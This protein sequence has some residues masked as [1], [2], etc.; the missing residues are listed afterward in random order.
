MYRAAVSYKVQSSPHF[1]K[2]SAGRAVSK[3]LP[4]PYHS[5]MNTLLISGCR[6]HDAPPQSSLVDVLVRGSTLDVIGAPPGTPA[7]TRLD[8]GGRTL[9]PGLIDLHL[10]GAGGADVLDGTPE[11]LET[12]SRALAR[13]GTTAFLATSVPQPQRGDRHLAAAAEQVGRKLGGARLLGQYLEGPFVNPEKRGGI[14][15]SSL[16]SPSRRVLDEILALTDGTLRIMTLAPELEGN[17]ALVERLAAEGIIAAFGHSAATYEQTRAGIAAGITHCTHLFNAMAGLHHREPGPLPA[18][19]ESEHVTVELISDGVHVSG[20]VVRFTHRAFGTERCVCI[21]DAM[22]TAGMPD[23]R[24]QY[25]GREF[26]SKEG[27][28]RYLD[29]TLIGTALSLREVALRFREYTGCTFAEAVDAATLVPARVLGIEE[30]KGSIAVG[31]DADLVLL[32]AD[33]SVWATLVEGEV[34]YQREG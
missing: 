29:G 34:V 16:L 32:D 33:D 31:K 12:M 23:G 4:P 15:L 8:A 13:M 6:L 24:Y 11:A 9:I 5:R 2:E 21:T 26:E 14:P 18:L 10:H 1:C 3:P 17:L 30:R 25:G 19:H 27:A 28:A 7:D 20:P 22:R